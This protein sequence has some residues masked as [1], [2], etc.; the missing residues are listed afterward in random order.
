MPVLADHRDIVPPSE[1]TPGD[2]RSVAVVGAGITG[3]VAAYALRRR[4]V[5]VTLYEASG[6]AGGAIRTSHTDGFL[7]EHGPNSFVTS[8]P[9][10]ALIAQ[11]DL[12]DD[13]VEANPNANRRYIVR[14]GM[15][16]SFPMTPPAMFG[17]RLF[18]LKAK[19]RVLLEPLVRTRATD[20]DES[21]ASF[22]R[23]RLGHEVLDY[24]VD[25]FISGIFAGD[26]ETLSMMHAFPRVFDLERKYGSLSAGLMATRGRMPTAPA[27]GP[28]SVPAL[29]DEPLSAAAPTR[30]RL[31]SFVD[32]MQTLTDA[33][34][35]SLVG[36]LR[37]GCPVRLLHR[38]E[39]HWVVDAGQDGASRSR[40]V[41]AVVMA[42]PAHVLAAME[43]PAE[44]RRHATLVEHV[45]YPPMSALTLGFE[46]AAVTHALDGFGMLIPSK[47]KRS[48][49]GALFSSSL[50]PARAPEGH[51]AI[52]CFVGG[53]RMP[54][55]AR[56]DT[57][58]LV[59]RVLIDLRQLLG[60]RG[61]PIFAKHVYWPRA[62]PQYTVGYQAV[63]DAANEMELSNPGLYL[64]GNYRNGVSVG[65]CVASGQQIAGQVARYLTRAG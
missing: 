25:P 34:E 53:T 21:V 6:H 8:A 26:T 48:I 31:I 63:K 1:Q 30:A 9:V 4:G 16:Q 47:E 13:V 22:V 17:T 20:A 24:A 55:R 39:G 43:L 27:N 52:T 33:L 29:D 23:R 41:D 37:L 32:G 38:N 49:L 15:L 40:T 65:D 10:E 14:N 57:D 35:A 7:A 42:T 11:L 44:L 61:E 56:E 59:E 46:R 58:L 5:N 19:L 51:V 54:E 62:I 12:Q 2:H 3:L 64:A 45:E 36:T 28:D 50:F 18:S 60:V